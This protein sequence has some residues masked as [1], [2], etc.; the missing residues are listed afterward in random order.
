MMM[1]RDKGLV[2]ESADVLQ[3]FLNAYINQMQKNKLT[4]LNKKNNDT[5]SR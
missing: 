4:I 1:E 5:L 2:R 3:H